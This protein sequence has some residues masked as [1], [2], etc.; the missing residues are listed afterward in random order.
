[1]ACKS[2]APSRRDVL[3]ALLATG[4]RIGA[5]SEALTSDLTA[6]TI[7]DA[8]RRIAAGTLTPAALTSAYLERIAGR[9]PVIHSFITVTAD[10]ARRDARAAASGSLRGIPIAHK[11]LFETAG[12]LTTAGSRLYRQ[13]IPTRDAAVVSLLARAG[14]VLLGKTNTHEL[15][16]GVTTI[17]P[18]YGTTLNPVDH[19]R[20]PGGS[21]GGSAAAVA[22][23][24]AAA[25]TGSDTGGSTR[26]P[27]AFCGCVG[28]KPS[29]GRVSTRGLLGACPTFDHVGLL[30]RTVADA[31]LLFRALGGRQVAPVP[32]RPRIG[33][34]RRFFFERLQPDVAQAVAQAIG[35]L[36]AAGIAV[37][38]R[39]LPVDEGT[40]SR[41][42]DPIVQEEIWSNLGPAWKTRPQNFSTDFA[43]F[44][45]QPPPALAEIGRARHARSVFQDQV[46]RAFDG[47]DVILTP[48]VPVTAPPIAGPI[49]ASL[50]LR[51]TWAFNAARTP[52]ISIPCGTDRDGLPIGLQLA[53]RPG[54]DE[55]LLAVA[56]RVASL[57]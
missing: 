42:F 29:F 11:D 53:A 17:N 14:A 43:T 19:L 55:M 56:E 39:D 52:A 22:A 34:A 3:A 41:V 36:R 24:L 30:T 57:V 45:R 38:D 26:I 16:G 20:I 50:I 49:D 31:A 10:R 21:S 5:A 7:V 28:F 15:G 13:H 18:F 23:Q 35:R 33:V 4:A 9:D 8:V 54:A 37:L 1:M 51:N 40:M 47:L 48:T 2:V 32:G 46:A 25:A 44:F 27:A 6:L 12:I